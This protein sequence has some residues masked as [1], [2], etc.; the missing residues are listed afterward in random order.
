MPSRKVTCE[1]MKNSRGCNECEGH[2][3]L[4]N[5]KIYWVNFNKQDFALKLV[6]ASDRNA[7]AKISLCC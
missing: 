3:E 2:Y 1:Y 7:A 6:L 5:Y 4:K